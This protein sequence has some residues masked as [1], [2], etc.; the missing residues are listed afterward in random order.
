[1]YIFFVYMDPKTLNPYDTLIEPFKG[2]LKRS[3]YT[4]NVHGAFM[5]LALGPRLLRKLSA[6]FWLSVLKTGVEEFRV[7]RLW[8]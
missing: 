6:L 2:T 4:V 5:S 3:P 8:Y 1:M 7:E